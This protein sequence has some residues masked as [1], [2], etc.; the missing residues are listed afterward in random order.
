M[1]EVKI[2]ETMRIPGTDLL[3]ETRDR[4]FYEASFNIKQFLND[5]E[6]RD[7]ELIE[8]I[9]KKIYLQ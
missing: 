2:K 8:D 5:Y 7:K 1:K 3:L 9:V 6:G 4:I